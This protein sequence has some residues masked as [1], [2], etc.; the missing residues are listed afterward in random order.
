LLG[1]HYTVDRPTKPGIYPVAFTEKLAELGNM[2]DQYEA[3][4]AAK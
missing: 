1:P 4:K 3:D 2:I